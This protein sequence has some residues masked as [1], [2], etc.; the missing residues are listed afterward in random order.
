MTDFV[1]VEGDAVSTG[2]AGRVTLFD[3]VI[4]RLDDRPFSSLQAAVDGRDATFTIYP[5]RRKSPLNRTYMFL[6]H[7]I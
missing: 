1:V 2:A 3:A 7:C 4:G 5:S 6:I